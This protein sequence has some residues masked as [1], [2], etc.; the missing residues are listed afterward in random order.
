ML[1]ERNVAQSC[2]LARST[3]AKYLR[4]AQEAGLRWQLP[5]GGDGSGDKSGPR[6]RRSGHR[7]Q[8]PLEKLKWKTEGSQGTEKHLLLLFFCLAASKKGGAFL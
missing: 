5:A 1:S 3:V 2:S 4:R 6:R 7:T 8:M